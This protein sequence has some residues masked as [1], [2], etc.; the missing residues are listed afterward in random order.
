MQS[1]IHVLS[2]EREHT[3]Y[4]RDELERQVR[5]LETANED[6]KRLANEKQQLME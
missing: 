2:K 4:E 3:Q 1:D 5:Q 6:N